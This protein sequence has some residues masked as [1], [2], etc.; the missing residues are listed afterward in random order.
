MGW[1][2]SGHLAILGV[3]YGVGMEWTHGHGGEVYGGGGMGWTSVFGKGVSGCILFGCI[4]FWL[5]STVL[6]SVV[7]FLSKPGVFPS[8]QGRGTQSHR[9]HRTQSHT[10]YGQFC[11]AIQPTSL[12]TERKV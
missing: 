7:F 5:Y 1:A 9:D 4:L 10:H 3:V 6:Y 11:D 2:W 12:W 8:G